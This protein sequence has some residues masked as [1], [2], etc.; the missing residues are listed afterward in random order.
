MT[1]TKT[2]LAFGGAFVTYQWKSDETIVDFL[3]RVYGRVL[4]GAVQYQPVNIRNLRASNLIRETSIKIQPTNKLSDHLHLMYGD[5]F[6][7]LL[8]FHHR[9]FLEYSLKRL[10][11]DS[12]NLSHS[13]LD[14]LKC[15]CLHPQ[16]L[17]ETLRT[18]DLLFPPLG[19]KKSRKFLKKWVSKENLDTRLLDHSASIFGFE[20]PPKDL[21]GLYEQYPY[22]GR[23]LSRLLRE[24]DDPTPITWWQKY[25]ERGRS[26][27]RMYECAIV[28]LFVTAFSALTATALAAVQVWISYCDWDDA[29]SRAWCSS[30][31]GTKGE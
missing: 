24:F 9:A 1:A 10:K 23:Q 21:H 29:P 8:V 16:L 2:Q 31:N 11:N 22:W 6:K 7:I 20:Q 14:A 12:D 17:S 5:D 30:K 26:P 19:D 13:T 18:L 28:A 3:D 15:G 4:I 27:R 25:T